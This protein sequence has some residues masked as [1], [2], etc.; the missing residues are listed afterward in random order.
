MQRSSL[1]DVE[2]LYPAR[3][4]EEKMFS[5]AGIKRT[6]V[7]RLVGVH[8]FGSDAFQKGASLL[9]YRL[10]ILMISHIKE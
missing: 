4:A 6:M 9:Y 8:I 3:E 1:G 2:Q 5:A 7:F 10:A